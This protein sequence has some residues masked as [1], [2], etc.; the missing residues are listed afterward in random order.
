[1]KTRRTRRVFL[2]V[3][4]GHFVAS[5]IRGRKGHRTIFC[6]QWTGDCFETVEIFLKTRQSIRKNVK[7]ITY[8]YLTALWGCKHLTSSELVT[9]IG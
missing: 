4:F 9:L 8:A 1:M 5:P 7:G 2:F 6:R 3:D